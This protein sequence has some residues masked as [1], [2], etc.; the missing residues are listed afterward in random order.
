MKHLLLPLILLVVTGKAH[1]QE[2]IASDRPGQTNS[3]LTLPASH[4]QIQTGYGYSKLDFTDNINALH[5]LSTTLRVAVISRLEINGSFQFSHSRSLITDIPAGTPGLTFDINS[6]G[7]RYDLDGDP[8]NRLNAVA[9]ADLVF[10]K[11]GDLQYN[12]RPAIRLNLDYALTDPL[13]LSSTVSLQHSRFYKEYF[14]T[15]NLNY[16][17]SR[18]SFF[19]EPY[20]IYTSDEL[21]KDTRYFANGG[22]AYR[23]LTYLQ[24]DASVGSELDGGQTFV[25]GGISLRFPYRK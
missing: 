15:A 22:L 16:N 14:V 17:R 2:S 20:L 4:A 24:L 23:P 6:V 12:L 13:H 25:Q 8:E 18:W 1:A 11:A 9:Q 19:L 5:L 10:Q 21:F 7:L 3:A